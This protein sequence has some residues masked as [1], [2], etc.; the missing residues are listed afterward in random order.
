MILAAVADLGLAAA[1]ASAE[2][3]SD[4]N[5]GSTAVDV[6]AAARMQQTDSYCP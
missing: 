3:A 5:N 4:F 2:N 6:A 1:V